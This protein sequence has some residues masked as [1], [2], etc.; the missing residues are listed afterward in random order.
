MFQTNV[1]FWAT[2]FIISPISEVL[3]F[4]PDILSIFFLYFW[5]AF[6][7]LKALRYLLAVIL[8]SLKLSG[9]TVNYPLGFSQLLANY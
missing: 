4:F 8:T 3:F 6:S 7:Y 9:L 1:I 2:F 5:L